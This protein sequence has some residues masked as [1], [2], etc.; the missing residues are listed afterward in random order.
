MRYPPFF[1]NA[2]K[3]LGSGSGLNGLLHEGIKENCSRVVNDCSV[4]GRQDLARIE[5]MELLI[6]AYR[7]VS[8]DIS[9]ASL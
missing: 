7:H 9:N 5:D 1:L 6:S 3:L 8:P 2:F 4:V